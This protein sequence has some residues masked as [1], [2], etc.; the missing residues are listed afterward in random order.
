MSSLKKTNDA[1]AEISATLLK[2]QEN[3]I[4]E[5]P[6]DPF[7]RLSPT[8]RKQPQSKQTKQTPSKKGKSQSTKIRNRLYDLYQAGEY[9]LFKELWNQHVNNGNISYPLP[10]DM[11]DSESVDPLWPVVRN[12]AFLCTHAL[13]FHE[14]GSSDTRKKKYGIYNVDTS[15]QLI[16]PNGF[17]HDDFSMAIECVQSLFKWIKVVDKRRG[18]NAATSNNHHTKHYNWVSVDI[19]S[20]MILSRMNLPDGVCD[21]FEQLIDDQSVKPLLSTWS[22]HGKKQN[23]RIHG[24]WMFKDIAD[25]LD[26]CVGLPGSFIAKWLNPDNPPHITDDGYLTQYWENMIPP[27]TRAYLAQQHADYQSRRKAKQ[28][29]KD[30]AYYQRMLGPG[31]KTPQSLQL[32]VIRAFYKKLGEY[33]EE[34]VSGLNVHK[35]CKR[36]WK[37]KT[38][39]TPKI[40]KILLRIKGRLEE[41]CLEHRQYKQIGDMLVKDIEE[42]IS[43]ISSPG[44]L[45]QSFQKAG[46][47]KYI[48]LSE[49]IAQR[50]RQLNRREWVSYK[51]CCKLAKILFRTHP[52]YMLNLLIWEKFNHVGPK[53]M[54]FCLWAKKLL[55]KNNVKRSKLNQQV[56]TLHTHQKRIAKVVECRN[57]YPN[58]SDKEI[59]AKCFPGMCVD[60]CA[61]KR[62]VKNLNTTGNT[63]QV[64]SKEQIAVDITKRKEN[65]PSYNVPSEVKKHISKIH[66]ALKPYTNRINSFPNIDRLYI[67]F[68]SQNDYTKMGVDHDTIALNDAEKVDFLDGLNS[69]IMADL[70]FVKTFYKDVDGGMYKR[71]KSKHWG[72]GDNPVVDNFRMKYQ[73]RKKH[74]QTPVEI[75]V[76][77]KT[78]VVEWTKAQIKNRQEHP[79]KLLANTR[80]AGKAARYNIRKK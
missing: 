52:N 22:K 19:E 30:N 67:T 57:S 54:K 12:N 59:I 72:W 34:K 53:I 44:Q 40:S 5:F 68:C 62:L 7:K 58:L 65:K 37:K 64:S 71:T 73:A 13:R 26:P 77:H 48:Q 55:H 25:A 70:L 31:V 66:H 60:G 9:E 76:K 43:N 16:P 78:K 36:F 49:G 47:Y 61:Y 21:V 51:D 6:G 14:M 27:I 56:K 17:S 33:V 28:S 8:K 10:S 20:G 18:S 41:P 23:P 1:I 63:Y 79:P 75:E 35:I 2:T 46:L 74:T 15:S 45:C 11:K 24:K 80:H 50:N 4:K 32:M 39:P 3:T 29:E 69:Y 42:W 38:R